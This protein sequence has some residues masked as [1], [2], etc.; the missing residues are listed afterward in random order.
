VEEVHIRTRGPMQALLVQTP[1]TTTCTSTRNAPMPP[2]QLH[3]LLSQRVQ[4]LICTRPTRQ[5]RQQLSCSFAHGVRC[6]AREGDA[7]NG[8]PAARGKAGATASRKGQSRSEGQSRAEGGTSRAEGQSRAE[9]GTS[10]S[11][12][13][14]G[15]HTRSSYAKRQSTARTSSSRKRELGSSQNDTYSAAPR[16]P[17]TEISSSSSSSS[18]SRSSSRVARNFGQDSSLNSSRSKHTTTPNVHQPGI[19]AARSPVLDMSLH[20]QQ[21]QQQ[22]RHTPAARSHALRDPKQ[23]TALIRYADSLDSL[24]VLGLRHAHLP[25]CTHHAGCY[26]HK[27]VHSI[28][29]VVCRTPHS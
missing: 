21:Q 2:A 4:W 6:R 16:L 14:R 20:Q 25:C 24:G 18:Q 22:Q 13:D 17:S 12:D 26:E 29:S 9:G 28:A 15:K 11:K 1:P 8:S 3:T 27:T 7:S 5:G 19:P 10:N 23:L